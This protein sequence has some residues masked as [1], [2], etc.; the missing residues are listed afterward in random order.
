LKIAADGLRQ[1]LARPDALSGLR[2]PEGATDLDTEAAVASLGGRYLVDLGRVDSALPVQAEAGQLTLLPS[3]LTLD[4]SNAAAIRRWAPM[5][6]DERQRALQLHALSYVGLDDA[7]LGSDG[8]ARDTMREFLAQTRQQSSIWLASAAQVAQWWQL[9]Q[10]IRLQ[11]RQEDAELLLT[12]LV[13]TDRPI[14]FPVAISIVPPPGRSRVRIIESQAA[15]T[16]ET[17]GDA[18]VSLVMRGLPAGAQ[19]IRLRFDPPL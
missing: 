12:L 19:R 10:K 11:V 2:T 8:E 3:T 14:D 7:S 16:L 9:R 6:G 18:S 5:L 15:M 1:A 17:R 13:D 4:S